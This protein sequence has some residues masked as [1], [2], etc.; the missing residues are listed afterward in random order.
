[1]LSELHLRMNRLRVP[2]PAAAYRL[3]EL[4][5]CRRHWAPPATVTRTATSSRA[6]PRMPRQARSVNVMRHAASTIRM[7][8][9][10]YN[11][12]VRGEVVAA[13]PPR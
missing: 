8:P 12:G 4:T 5:L 6:H 11:Q 1:M 9:V 7:A 10:R 2:E 3:S 13:I